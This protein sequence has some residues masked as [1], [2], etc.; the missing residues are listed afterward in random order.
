MRSE[1]ETDAMTTTPAASVPIKRSHYHTDLISGRPIYYPD[2]S[3]VIAADR[4]KAKLERKFSKMKMTADSLL[5]LLQRFEDRV[6]KMTEI[7]ELDEQMFDRLHSNITI[8]QDYAPSLDFDG[9]PCN[10]VRILLRNAEAYLKIAVS[11]KKDH[12]VR[13]FM[14]VAR[15]LDTWF[16]HVA[17]QKELGSTGQY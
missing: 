12:D 14:H 4:S 3:Q 8:A 1:Q 7:D 6:K 17:F 16:T 5:P 13:D 9:I 2:Q 11:K 15:M 10:G